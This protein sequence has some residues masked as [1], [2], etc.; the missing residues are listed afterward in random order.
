[1]A[2]DRISSQTPFVLTLVA[3]VEP[4]GAGEIVLTPENISIPASVSPTLDSLEVTG[5]AEVGGT[6]DVTGDATF[7]NIAA[8]GNAEVGGTLD[9]T[10]DTTVTNLT[11]GLGR[12][13]LNGAEFFGVNIAGVQEFGNNSDAITGGLVPGDVYRTAVGVAMIVF[14]P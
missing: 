9:V 8:T 7:D 3:P 11:V 13:V 6:L 5:N 10:G 14:T 4:N 12:T 2:V 1:M